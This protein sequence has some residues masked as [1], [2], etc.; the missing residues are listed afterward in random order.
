MA[1]ALLVYLSL[2][3]GAGAE[4]FASQ[5]LKATFKFYHE[6]S[7]STCFLVKRDKDPSLYL[8]TCAHTVEKTKGETAV[9]VLR[10][11]HPDGSYERCDHTIS[12]RKAETPLW[13]RHEKEDVAVLK[14]GEKLPMG[15]EGLPESS[16]L[17]EASLQAA[18]VHLCSPLFVLT[19]PQRFEANA[20]GF[21]VARQGIFASPPLLPLK[22][23]PTFLG[24]FTTFSGDS[25]GPVFF[26]SE[27]GSPKV[28][29]I[30]IGQHHHN[31]RTNSELEERLQRQPLGLGI[32]LHA[33]YVR[34]VIAAAAGEK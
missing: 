3:C 27:D 33:T 20:A 1:L 2:V 34:E 30:T 11:A 17:N 24:D 13:V 15:V 22:S 29:G 5:V 25:G 6:D 21:P 16:L 18:G 32:I 4:D 31:E 7:T 9:L 28:A 12:I 26:R 14:L 19:F 8:V 10:E 23:H